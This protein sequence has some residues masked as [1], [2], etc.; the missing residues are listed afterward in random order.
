MHTILIILTFY[1]FLSIFSGAML[2]LIFDL[3]TPLHNTNFEEVFLGLIRGF[4][5]NESRFGNNDHADF[6]T[7]AVKIKKELHYYSLQ[8]EVLR[9]NALSKPML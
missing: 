5:N 9:L 3:Q 6:E 4:G 2:M 8:I 7:L 1:A